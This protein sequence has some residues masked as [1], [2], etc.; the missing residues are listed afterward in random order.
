LGF[1]S[2]SALEQWF[3][4]YESQRPTILDGKIFVAHQA[5]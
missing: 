1:Q 5:Q 4:T 2:C 3:S